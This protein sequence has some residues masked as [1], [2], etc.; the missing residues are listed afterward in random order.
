VTPTPF[1]LGVKSL[2]WLATNSTDHEVRYKAAIALTSTT[3]HGL[4]FFADF[5]DQ[6]NR[7]AESVA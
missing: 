5:D 7:R 3:E 4:P 6:G 2:I 1:D